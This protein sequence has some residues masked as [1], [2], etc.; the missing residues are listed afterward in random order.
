MA[1]EW[2]RLW[3]DMP[4]DPKW[5]TVAR[6]SAQPIALVQAV[7]MHLLVDAS[8]NVTRGHATVTPEDLASALD[9][10]ED[11]IEAILSAMQGRVLDGQ[12]LSGWD[13]R[14]PKREDK[15]SEETGA[16]SAAQRKREQRERARL[17]AEE[18]VSRQCH[19]ESR[20]V[21]L[22]KD[23]EEDKEKEEKNTPQ[24]PRKRGAAKPVVH[25]LSVEDLQ[26]QGVPADVA[27]EF[28]ALRNRKRA[29]LTEIALAGIRRE[30][31]SI[32]WTLEQALRKCIER[33]WQGFDGSW[34]Q[35]MPHAQAAGQPALNKQEALEARNLEI[36]RRWA[37]RNA[38]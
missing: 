20:E 12:Y 13:K 22:D 28:I 33:G 29:V 14:Q 11:A 36:A 1:N 4:N 8:R 21:T 18:G 25:S 34:V 9:V 6:V 26:A 7:Y 17:S 23:K 37:E 15:G 30:A 16:K 32:G 31:D 38:G 10:T 27:G 24:P 35:N 2:L 5:R 3:H 19:D